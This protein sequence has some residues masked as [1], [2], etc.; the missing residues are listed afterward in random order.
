MH[1][2]CRDAARQVFWPGGIDQESLL[3][4][5]TFWNKSFNEKS[6]Y[7]APSRVLELLCEL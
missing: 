4:W 2:T 5:K 6:L 1:E 7:L 3:A